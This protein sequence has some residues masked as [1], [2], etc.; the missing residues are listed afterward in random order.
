MCQVLTDLTVNTVCVY[1][2]VCVHIVQR[3]CVTISYGDYATL[4]RR[5][6][7]G[8]LP[9]QRGQIL[10]FFEFL[11]LS[12][13]TEYLLSISFQLKESMKNHRCNEI[14]DMFRTGFESPSIA[15]RSILT[16][17][18]WVYKLLYK[19]SVNN[20]QFSWNSSISFV[21]LHIWTWLSWLAWWIRYQVI[22]NHGSVN[23][24][25]SFW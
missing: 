13:L 7:N 2:C 5:R 21:F 12:D 15:F 18:G 17:I 8:G 24:K 3:W 20:T 25:M 6:T 22:L 16:V 9:A 14:H 4:L 11:D 19:K 1:V 10:F 23:F